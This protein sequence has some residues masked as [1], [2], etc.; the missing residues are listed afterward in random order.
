MATFSI[1]AIAS[2]VGIIPTIGFVAKEG[3]LTAFLHEAVGGAVW[4]VVGLVG[5]V[6]GSVL[7]AA[8]GIRFVWGAFWTKKGG[9]RHRAR[10]HGMARPADR[11]PRSPGAAGGP[12]RSSPDSPRRCSTSCWHRTPHLLRWRRRESHRRR[13]RRTSSSG[14]DSSRRCASRSPRSRRRRPVPG[15][16]AARTLATRRR[17]CP[18][19]RPTSTTASLRGIARLSVLTT[20]LTQRG[21]LPVYV[22]T[23]FVVLRGSRGHRSAG[24]PGRTGSAWMPTRRP[25]QLIGGADD[26]RGRTRGRP[27]AASATRRRAGLG[28]GPRHGA[29]LRHERRARPGAH[30][31]PRR[32]GHARR[33]R[34]RPAAHPVAD[35]RA[36]RLGAAGAACRARRRRR[37]DHGRG[38]PRRHGRPVSDA[39][40]G[41]VARP[42][43]RAS[44]TA[45]TS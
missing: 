29:A 20:S 37:R 30:A 36:Q 4:G 32:D 5:V 13:T 27:R 39:D 9:G 35:G 31:D 38:R 25:M 19:A 45:R 22:G 26:D 33:L 8:Y 12:H 11:L 10:A 40:L 44:A 24:G 14:T 43:V 28:H 21:S 17:C 16:S 42:R 18:S 7:T 1:I 41:I 2:M 23:I 34:A 3:A 6:L 15:C